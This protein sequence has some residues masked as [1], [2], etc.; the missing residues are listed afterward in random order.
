MPEPGSAEWLDLVQEE[1]LEPERVIVD[2]H[3]H[4]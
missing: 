3:H 4:L 1:I 2:P